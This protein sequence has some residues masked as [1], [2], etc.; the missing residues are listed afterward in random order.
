MYFNAE[1]RYLYSRRLVTG[2]SVTG[3]IQLPDFYQSVNWMT[4]WSNV[5]VQRCLILVHRYPITVQLPYFLYAIQVT[6]W[7][8]YGKHI[9][10]E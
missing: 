3:N 8:P 5:I 4:E 10:W 9:E 2:P 6:I 7:L 1:K